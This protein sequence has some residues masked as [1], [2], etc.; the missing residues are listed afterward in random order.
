MSDKL[1]AA[2]ERLGTPRVDPVLYEDLA[3]VLHALAEAEA[4]IRAMREAFDLLDLTCA[5]GTNCG[6]CGGCFARYALSLPAVKAY[7]VTP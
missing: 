4:A 7:G 3:L 5:E 6:E 1:T 2:R